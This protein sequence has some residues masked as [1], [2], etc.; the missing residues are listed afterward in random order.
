VSQLPCRVPCLCAMPAGLECQAGTLL[1]HCSA[2]TVSSGAPCEHACLAAQLDR[3][4]LSCLAVRLLT[5][6]WQARRTWR[7]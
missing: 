4:L 3:C 6:R 7:G 1:T 2:L 5:M